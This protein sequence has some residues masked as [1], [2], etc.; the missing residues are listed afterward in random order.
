ML[1]HQGKQS[2]PYSSDAIRQMAAKG[3]I[4]GDMQI[5]SE[6]MTDWKP[7]SSVKG[8]NIPPPPPAS[9]TGLTGFPPPPAQ[10]TADDEYEA[11]G[12]E[13]L[14]VGHPAMFRNRP[15]LFSFGVLGILIGLPALFSGLSKGDQEMALSGLGV[16]GG[17]GLLMLYWWIKTLGTTLTV[18]G[19]KATLRLGLLSKHTSDVML[20]DV[21]NVQVSQGILQRLLGVGAVGI[22][23]AG[24]SGVEIAVAGIFDPEKVKALIE[25]GRAIARRG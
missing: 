24:Q 18:T 19:E 8:L 4:T 21:R 2:G 9:T 14:Y 10:T 16:S 23:S 12:S 13:V 25:R 22:S 20:A 3:E 1:A 6:G 11:S 5:W 15:I 17:V 7:V